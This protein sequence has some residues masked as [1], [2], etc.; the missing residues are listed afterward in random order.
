MQLEEG[1][2][3]GEREVAEE[4]EE[5]EEEEEEEQ[6]EEGE[7]E[8]DLGSRFL[9]LLLPPLP[10]PPP[11]FPHEAH[12][13]P[14]D[15]TRRTPRKLRN[16]FRKAPLRSSKGIRSWSSAVA[17]T[18]PPLRAR[19]STGDAVAQCD[20]GDLQGWRRGRWDQDRH[21]GVA[22]PRDDGTRRPEAHAAG[23]N[24]E[25]EEGRAMER[26]ADALCV[27][28]SPSPATSCVSSFM[29]LSAESQVVV[30]PLAI[31]EPRRNNARRP[32]THQDS[33]R[34]GRRS[35]GAPTRQSQA[36]LFG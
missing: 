22:L 27:Q 31:R 12:V 3:E 4:E 26:H 18:L 14:Q 34:A 15:G 10:P 17:R 24:A 7:E 2:G 21:A 11:S 23:F 32:M 13:R 28:L 36:Q 25:H 30:V 8:E 20:R 33:A 5:K 1:E 6:E 16:C 19:H 29:I 35:R 9:H